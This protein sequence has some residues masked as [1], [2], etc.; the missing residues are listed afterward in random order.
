MKRM[1]DMKKSSG[2]NTDQADLGRN[3]VPYPLVVSSSPNVLVG[4]PVGEIWLDGDRLDFVFRARA[5]GYDS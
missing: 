4:D 2:L 3:F 5:R 1:K